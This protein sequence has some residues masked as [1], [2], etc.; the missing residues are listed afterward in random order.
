MRDLREDVEDF[1]EVER[2]GL[3]DRL[4]VILGLGNSIIIKMLEIF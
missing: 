2:L 1:L 3:L 4:Y